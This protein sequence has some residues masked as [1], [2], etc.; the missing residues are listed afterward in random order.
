MDDKPKFVKI[1][2]LWKG[3][4]GVSGT[5]DDGSDKGIKIYLYKNDFKKTER[6]PDLT[7][8]MSKDNADR[9][10]LKYFVKDEEPA[11]KPMPKPNADGEIDISDIPF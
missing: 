2:A 5:L 1:G 11:A 8:S 3:D 9:L 6:H 10:G 4:K 7:I